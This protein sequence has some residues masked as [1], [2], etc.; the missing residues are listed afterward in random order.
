[1]IAGGLSSS[2]QSHYAD[3]VLVQDLLDEDAF[4]V[5]KVDYSGIDDGFD[6]GSKFLSSPVTC[7]AKRQEDGSMRGSSAT[8][9]DRI[10]GDSPKAADVAPLPAVVAPMSVNVTPPMPTIVGP[11]APTAS[12]PRETGISSTHEPAVGKWRDL[13][14]SN[15]SSDC[16]S[17]LTHF[18][19][20]NCSESC[21]LLSVDLGSNCDVWKSCIVGYVAGKSPGF[22]AL[23]SIISNTWT[24]K[25]PY[26]FM[27]Q[28]G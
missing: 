4:D 24:V 17:K 1:M 6:S 23:N 22:K 26:L 21:T 5:D 2:N 8:F 13:F 16:C 19:G 14:A 3:D 10:V 11:Q 7:F 27:T 18:S 15:R 20:I 9:S 12:A 28:G 25:P